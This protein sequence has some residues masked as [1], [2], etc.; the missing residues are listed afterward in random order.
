MPK[1]WLRV[2]IIILVSETNVRS[3][4][5]KDKRVDGAQPRADVRVKLGLPR[6]DGGR[7]RHHGGRKPV[8][9]LADREQPL[10]IGPRPTVEHLGPR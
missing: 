8:R 1:I 5:V 10:L 6:V 2:I 7:Q 9:G 4:S 3:N